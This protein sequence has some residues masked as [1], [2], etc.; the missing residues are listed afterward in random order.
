MTESPVHM[1]DEIRAAPQAVARQARVGAAAGELGAR[2]KR[3]P[4]R[5]VVTCARGSSA[6]AATFA[7]HLIELYLGI[8]VAAAAPNIASVYRRPLDLRRPAVPGGLAIRPQRRSA[9]ERRHG[10]KAAG[11]LTVAIV[12]DPESPLA[13]VCDIVLPIAAGPERSVAATKTVVASLAALLRLVAC[14]TEDERLP[15]A[16]DRLPERLAAA[17]PARLERG[18][19]P[20]SPRRRA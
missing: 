6:H 15:A 13:A 8:P 9:G 20:R 10:A 12:N 19:R 11:A 17:S 14:W 5:V 4:P 1:L 16:L 18:A 2:L 3:R 7:K